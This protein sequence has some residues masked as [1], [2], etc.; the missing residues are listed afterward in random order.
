VKEGSRVLLVDDEE[1]I[2]ES[3]RDLLLACLPRL[4]VAVAPSAEEAHRLL[5]L[6]RFDLLITDYRM[7]G[8]DGLQL[9]ARVDDERA[10]HRVLMTAY[11]EL[12]LATRAI[13]GARIEAFIPKP[14]EPEHVVDLVGR[15]LD[16]TYSE[17]ER[18]AAFD[19]TLAELRRR[20]ANEK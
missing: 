1:D 4:D 3:L 6:E 19:A 11:P 15:L 13:T 5:D 9:L 8:E 12:D 14:F 2:R 17:R 7:P 16:G 10:A 18:D 20:T